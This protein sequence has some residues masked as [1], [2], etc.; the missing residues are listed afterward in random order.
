MLT[1]TFHMRYQ[2]QQFM[3]NVNGEA[4]TQSKGQQEGR[5]E[6]TLSDQTNKGAKL[7]I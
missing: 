7:A 4:S 5:K 3:Y 6:R 1:M 2:Q